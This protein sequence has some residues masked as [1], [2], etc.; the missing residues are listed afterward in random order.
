MDDSEVLTLAA[1]EER[2][3]C[4]V[5]HPDGGPRAS[6]HPAVITRDQ[7]SRELVPRI[8]KG[9]ENVFSSHGEKT[10]RANCGGKLAKDET[11][12]FLCTDLVLGAIIPRE[13]A[14][15]L[16][17]ALRTENTK[18]I[19]KKREQ[20]GR[21]RAREVSAV[22]SW[23]SISL[24]LA[25]LHPASD[26]LAL[27]VSQR[28]GSEMTYL[29][30]VLTRASAVISLH[31]ISRHRNFSRRLSPAPGAL[32]SWFRNSAIS[33]RLANMGTM[34][35]RLMSWRVPCAFAKGT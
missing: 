20:L 4:I 29:K 2:T 10:L 5:A 14:I 26:L 7:I 25:L 16:G 17:E 22:S 6:G 1:L 34:P 8:I 11:Y 33:F 32:T 3:E 18:K 35:S 31:L 30:S 28:M 15:K 21:D 9:V 13:A 23:S 12:G 27:P 19:K 24:E